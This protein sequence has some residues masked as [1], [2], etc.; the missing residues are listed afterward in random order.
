MRHVEVLMFKPLVHFNRV[1]AMMAILL[2]GAVSA[3]AQTPKISAIVFAGASATPLYVAQDK[4]FFAKEGLSVDIVATPSSLAQMTGLISGK[5]QIAA[6]ALDNLIAYQE[7]PASAQG[8][9]DLVAILGISSTELA[10]MA[11]PEIKSVADL[12][13]RKLAVDSLT[14]GFAFVLRHML[15][16]KGLAPSDY[17]FVAVGSTRERVQALRDKKADAALVSEPFTTEAKRDG[18]SFLGEAVSTVGPYAANVHIVN[19]PW[20]TANGPAMVSYIRAIMTAI[21][22]I[23]DPANR[24]EA[25]QILAKNAGIPPAAARPSIEG[26]V[27]GQAAI[28]RK[29]A[30]NI[31]GVRKVLELRARYAQGATPLGPPE[32]YYDLK[33]YSEAAAKK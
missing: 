10:L 18:F 3:Q 11:Q 30:L 20:A 28:D 2:L 19:R 29:A 12:K 17:E 8:K 33:W 23:Y 15:E 21:D 7:A 1:V 31:E 9:P 13:G 4:G 6:T 5:Y 26:I 32:K 14:T 24:D 27:S 16:Q 25:V 22:W